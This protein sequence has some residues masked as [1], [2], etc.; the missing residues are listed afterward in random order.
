ML[1]SVLQG[2][3]ASICTCVLHNCLV[4]GTQERTHWN[5][6]HSAASHGL[7]WTI[8][9]GFFFRIY[10]IVYI[11][12]LRPFIL[13]TPNVK[14]LM[15]SQSECT[16]VSA[17]PAIWTARQNLTLWLRH[18]YAYGRP[19]T[20]DARCSLY[21]LLSRAVCRQSLDSSSCCLLMS[22]ENSSSN[23]RRRL[24]QLRRILHQ[25]QTLSCKL[26]SSARDGR[27]LEDTVIRVLDVNYMV[28]VGCPGD[29]L[30]VGDSRVSVS[31]PHRPELVPR[32]YAS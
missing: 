10:Y 8:L 23:S 3:T 14:Q 30:E 4:I 32:L 2:W 26:C 17:S 31:H 7:Q 5:V 15:I 25:S 6:S 27:L 29:W 11:M 16:R 20:S 22:S 24:L 28:L 9:V 18:V 19:L 21:M 1:I 12:F 13:P